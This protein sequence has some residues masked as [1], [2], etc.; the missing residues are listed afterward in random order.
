MT[1]H[2]RFDHCR[3]ASEC[4]NRSNQN[5]VLARK[6]RNKTPRIVGAMHTLAGEQPDHDD[7][8]LN[9]G[10]RF[11]QRRRLLQQGDSPVSKAP[12]LVQTISQLLGRSPRSSVFGGPMRQQNNSHL[13]GVDSV[14]MRRGHGRISDDINQ[15][16]LKP[17][18]RQHGD[19]TRAIIMSRFVNEP[20]Q[21]DAREIAVS[22]KQRI[23]NDVTR[24]KRPD[25]IVHAGC[26]LDE[27]WRDFRRD[28]LPG[29][30]PGQ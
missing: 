23:Y 24:R 29:E 2:G 5:H 8:P 9:V 30:S 21:G 15:R 13:F 14:C 10:N 3:D 12:T 26:A 17:E 7:R 19:G 20:W 6:L 27:P 1:Y 28:T 18:G 16:G 25:R 11:S 22:E 4:S